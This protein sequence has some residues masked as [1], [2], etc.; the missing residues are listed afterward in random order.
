MD[1]N[2]VQVT[3]RAVTQIAAQAKW[4][5][6]SDH[7]CVCHAYPPE[8]QYRLKSMPERGIRQYPRSLTYH[9]FS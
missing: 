8:E 6:P 9:Q 3:I 7:A 2:P 1:A 5:R 4:N